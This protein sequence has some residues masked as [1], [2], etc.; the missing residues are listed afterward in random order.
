M[1]LLDVF[2]DSRVLSSP[3]ISALNNQAAILRVVDQEVYF[4]IEVNDTVNEETGQLTG[5]EYTIEE[6]TV[7]VGFVMN[8]LPQISASDEIIL[9]LKPAVTRVL[10]YRSAPVPA[11]LGG[12]SGSVQNFVPIT[13][14][15]ELDSIISLRDGEVAVLGGLL[16]DRTGDNNRSVPGLSKLPGIGALF[17]N[18]DQRTYK[19]EFIV[20]IKASVI[21]NPSLN[22]DYSDYLKLLPDSDF[23]QRDRENTYLPPKQK[24]TR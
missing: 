24:K 2:G 4:N 19:T 10:E 16:E 18:I 12:L 6:N 8:V 7:D 9:N 17:E 11:A 5:R 21:K 1:Q 14:V 15:R 22:G 13:R 23:I 20:F 3:R